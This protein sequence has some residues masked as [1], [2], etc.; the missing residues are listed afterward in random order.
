MALAT[1]LLLVAASSPA[2]TYSMRLNLHQGQTFSYKLLVQR[3]KPKTS[4]EFT[5]TFKISKVDGNTIYM[6]GKFAKLKIDNKDRTKDL[7]AV[8]G[9]G[10]VTWPWTIYSRRTGSVG[11]IPIHEGKPDVMT[12]LAETGIYLA[13]FQRQDV[14]PGDSWTGS[15]TATGGCT[16]GKFNFKEV[17]SVGGK[18]LAVFEVTNIMFLRPQ[19]EQV[20]PMKM[21]VDLASGL[22][23]TVDYKVKDGKTGQISHFVQTRVS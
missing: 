17:K 16:S 9:D 5:N 7:K 20:G 2:K 19:D 12:C 14:K 21:V 13:Y 22:P 6:D 10:V 15:T 23:T 3:D 8:V 4:A 11:H 18:Q 1:I